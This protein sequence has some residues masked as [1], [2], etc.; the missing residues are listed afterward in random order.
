MDQILRFIQ[1]IVLLALLLFVIINYEPI[2]EFLAELCK[3]YCNDFFR[4]IE[5]LLKHRRV[6]NMQWIFTRLIALNAVLFGIYLVTSAE[7]DL[8]VIIANVSSA[9]FTIGLIADYGNISEN[10]KQTNNYIKSVSAVIATF[11]LLS[12]CINQTK[13]VIYNQQ[14][15]E[16][17]VQFRGL[18]IIFMVIHLA[19]VVYYSVN[20]YNYENHPS[21][22]K[23]RY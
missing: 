23:K 10:V 2:I 13:L 21:R 14:C 4:R 6:T 3:A 1:I 7:H 8:L 18:S 12:L 22:R 15:L 16:R 20:Q 9:V 19:G 5:P 11:S 17:I